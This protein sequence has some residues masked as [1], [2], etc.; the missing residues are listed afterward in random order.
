H[1]ERRPV[2]RHVSGGPNPIYQK[3]NSNMDA[4]ALP[5]S[6]VPMASDRPVQGGGETPV[7]VGDWVLSLLLISLPIVGIIMVL[8]WAFGGGAPPSKA[9]YAEALLIWMLI[10]LGLVIAVLILI[11]VIG[12]AAGAG[13]QTG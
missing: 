9:N 4:Q 3:E 7:S 10:G 6:P 5:T 8:V 2:I 11:A 12:V 13:G 1:R